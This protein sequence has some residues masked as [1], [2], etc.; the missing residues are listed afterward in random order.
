MTHEEELVRI[1]RRRL[2][3][4]VEQVKAFGKSVPPHIVMEIEDARTQIAD[5]KESA[6]KSGLT[7]ADEEIDRLMS[8]GG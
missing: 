3:I 4:Q 1:L 6:R 2:R 7:I 8:A 5:L